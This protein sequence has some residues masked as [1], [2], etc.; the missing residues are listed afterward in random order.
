MPKTI[1]IRVDDD[2]KAQVDALFE[3]LGLDTTTATRMFYRAALDYCGIPF[4]V[5]QKRPNAE[6]V[7]AIMESE[8]LLRDPDAKRYTRVEELFADLEKEDEG[9]EV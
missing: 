2:M 9:N 6:T 4:E 8:R 7:A 3:S 5:R 1:Q